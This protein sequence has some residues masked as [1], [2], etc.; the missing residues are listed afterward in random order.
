[1]FMGTASSLYHP[2]SGGGFTQ[3]AFYV[4]DG[5]CFLIPVFIRAVGSSPGSISVRASIVFCQ[6]TGLTAGWQVPCTIPRNLDLT[7]VRCN[8][9]AGDTLSQADADEFVKLLLPHALSAL[10]SKRWD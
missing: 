2:S 8:M 10:Y 5:A 7:L 1:M 3:K 9:C 6:E 4:S